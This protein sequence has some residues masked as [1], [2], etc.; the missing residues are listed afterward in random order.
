[1][2]FSFPS[3]SNIKKKTTKTNQQQQQQQ[4]QGMKIMQYFFILK[5]Q[6]IYVPSRFLYF[7][8]KKYEKSLFSNSGHNVPW[9]PELHAKNWKIPLK[10]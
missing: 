6:K 1:M 9:I 5:N 7:R 3:K 2:N 10:I 4:Q 8:F